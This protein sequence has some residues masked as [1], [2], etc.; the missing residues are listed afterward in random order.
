MHSQGLCKASGRCNAIGYTNFNLNNLVLRT[1]N[2]P[3]YIA[4]GFK[5]TAR[6]LNIPHEYIV[7]QTPDDNGD[8]ESFH[9][10]LKTDYIR[11]N[12]LESYE[13]AK[14]LIEYASNEYNPVS[15][16]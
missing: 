3:Q 6:L 15:S 5:H 7:K 9:N 12:D 11:L 13:D 1:D 4:K 14:E 8:I 16:T 10:S 2:S